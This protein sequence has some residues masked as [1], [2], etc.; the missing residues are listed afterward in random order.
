MGYLPLLRTTSL[1][2]HFPKG[3]GFIDIVTPSTTFLPKRV[4]LLKISLE[5]FGRNDLN[6]NRHSFISL[7]C[8]LGV[9]SFENSF[10]GHIALSTYTYWNMYN[11]FCM[12][13]AMWY[14][15]YLHSLYRSAQNGSNTLPILIRNCFQWWHK[16]LNWKEFYDRF[17]KM[18]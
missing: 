9:S 4:Q 16:F 14:M 11:V 13:C 6:C 10:T 2:T 12:L 15:R 8:F 18:S 3:Y 5:A 1:E 7:K 17:L